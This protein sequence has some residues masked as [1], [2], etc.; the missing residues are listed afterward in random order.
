MRHC[1]R[2]GCESEE[3]AARCPDCDE[4]LPSGSAPAGP[5]GEDEGRPVRLCEVPD[6]TAGDILKGVLA[7]HGIP[8]FVQRHGP[9]T[10]E[11][12]RVTDGLTD[13]RAILMVPASRLGA[14]RAVLDVVESGRVIWPEGM[15]PEEEDEA[16]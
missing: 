4:D 3:A 14:A 9:I 2:C 13:D 5:Q 15:E 8:A 10:G 6:V 12:G 11:L 1:P 7:E 16:T